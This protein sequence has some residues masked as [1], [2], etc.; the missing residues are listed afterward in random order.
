MPPS[1]PFAGGLSNGS[2]A[3]RSGFEWYDATSPAKFS[4]D[5]VP[6]LQS[7]YI[8]IQKQSGTSLLYRDSV[9]KGVQFPGIVDG[10]MITGTLNKNLS[11]DFDGDGFN[12][13][14]GSYVINASQNKAVFTLEA[15]ADTVRY[16]PVFHIKNW[17]VSGKPQYVYLFNASDTMPLAENYGY[18]CYFNRAD[19]GLVI[20]L[21]TV[22]RSNTKIYISYDINLAVELS[23][24]VAKPGDNC[25]TLLWR[26]ESESENLGFLVY[27]RINTGFFDS[28]SANS[29]DS[30]WQTSTLGKSPLA[31]ISSSDTSWICVSPSLIPGASGG[32]SQGPSSYRWIDHSVANG[33]KYDYRL[34]AVDFGSNR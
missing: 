9:S 29:S 10:D 31:K 27:R 23:S 11:G 13:A 12:E 15:S 21:D 7:F 26:T 14:D 16:N 24:F 2:N 25:D 17:T 1:L 30:S 32:T 34:D 18:N 22:I 19:T 28:L 4:K 3:Y 33:I 8:D 5:S 6:I 20:Q